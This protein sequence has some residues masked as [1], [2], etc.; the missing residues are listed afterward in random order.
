MLVKPQ[1]VSRLTQ[2]NAHESQTEPEENDIVN[3][4]SN[5]AALSKVISKLGQVTTSSAFPL[6]TYAEGPGLVS[7]KVGYVAKFTIYAMDRNG[8]ACGSGMTY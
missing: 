3:F 1:M 5:D 4:T 7:A 2:L 8:E 6:L